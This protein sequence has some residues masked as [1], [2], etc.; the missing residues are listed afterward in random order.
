[1]APTQT[2]KPCRKYLKGGGCT[3]DHCFN[4]GRHLDGDSHCPKKCGEGDE[5]A[6]DAANNDDEG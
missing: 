3:E 2:E 6:D 1:M 5:D 4:C